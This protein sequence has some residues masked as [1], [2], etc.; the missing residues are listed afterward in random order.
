MCWCVVRQTTNVA[1]DGVAT[2][3]C[4][5]EYARHRFVLMM[6]SFHLMPRIRLWHVMWNA[7]SL[8]ESSFNSVQ[9]SAP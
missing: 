7:C 6:K 5:T 1:E 9:V 4:G 3:G 8:R 2:S